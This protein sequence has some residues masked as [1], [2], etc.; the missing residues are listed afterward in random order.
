MNEQTLNPAIASPTGAKRIET[1][2]RA[3]EAMSSTPD[4][5]SKEAE[6]PASPANGQS[7]QRPKSAPSP[8][9]A[10]QPTE[11]TRKNRPVPAPPKANSVPA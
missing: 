10:W 5:T 11:P 4:A 8:K 2:R 3:K 1:S 6:Q 7:Q 9:H